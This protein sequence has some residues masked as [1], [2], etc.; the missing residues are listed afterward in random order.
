MPSETMPEFVLTESDR[1]EMVERFLRYVRIHTRSSE[2]SDSFPS[3]ACQWDLLKLLEQEM[4]G[5]GLAEVELTE[6][7]Y[8]FGTLP[9]NLPEGRTAPVLGLLAHV[10]T[11]CGTEG[12]HVNPQIRENYDGGDLPLPGTEGDFI[13][14]QKNPLLQRCLGHTIITS[15]GTTLLG[16]DD[17][18]G[19]AIIMT[20]VQWL[21]RHPEV[22]HGKVRLG[23]TPDEETGTGTRF[24][25]VSRFGAKVAYTFDG[26]LLGEIEAE[27]FCGDSA[28]VTLTGVDVHPGMAKGRMVNALRAASD[29]LSRLPQDFLPETTEK[30]QPYLHPYVIG[31]EVGKVTIKFLV[32]GFTV[33]DLEAREHELLRITKETEEAFPGLK[34]DVLIQASYRNMK[35]VL[36]EHP[37]VIRL[38][39]EAVRR[40]GVEPTQSYIRG[41]TDGSA[42]CFKGLP[43]PNIFA[44]GVNFHGRHEWVSV[45]W[46]EKSAETGLHLVHLWGQPGAGAD[47]K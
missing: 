47:G 39:V 13:L 36:D 2:E 20:L 33:E 32:R 30:R 37:E 42:L 3:T 10:D 5:I 27:T 28:T 14:A 11:Y 45:E 21:V 43:T 1:A 9:S 31:G 41:G 8:L 40:T 19:V 29:L 17:K 16:A 35:T 6:F 4:I 46:M 25:D 18:A 24:F 38:A 22:P 23:F 15:D 26:S 34:T 44:G 12:E 7:G